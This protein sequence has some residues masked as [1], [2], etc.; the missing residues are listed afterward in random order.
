MANPLNMTI[1]FYQ[2]HAAEYFDETIS[3]SMNEALARFMPR[4]SKGSS[5]LDLGCGSGRD[6]LYFIENGFAVTALDGCEALAK[7][8]S[9]HIGQEV[10]VQ[11][12]CAL[13]LPS[14][15]DGIWACASLLHLPKK[16]MLPV[17]KYLKA[18][19]SPNGVFYASFKAIN[20]DEGLTHEGVD[21]KGRFFA[22]YDMDEL[23][24]LF[25]EVG[26]KAIEQWQERKPLRGG[27]QTWLNLIV[28]HAK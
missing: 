21:S 3:L 8:A 16:D 15:F 14:K 26:F 10:L 25:Q 11:D 13:S 20:E 27:M 6:S 1:N 7:K 17:L 12:F 28:T 5:V 22:Y 18:H 2:I 23:I 19:L 4:L 24:E 9:L